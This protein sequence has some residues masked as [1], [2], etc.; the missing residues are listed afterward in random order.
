MGLRYK[1]DTIFVISTP[2]NSP[3][4]K[5][6]LGKFCGVQ[7]LQCTL[8]NSTK[9]RLRYKMDTIFVISTSENRPGRSSRKEILRKFRAKLAE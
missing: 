6:N 3:I 2:N 7:Y 5:H 1:M 4:S 8:R 9:L